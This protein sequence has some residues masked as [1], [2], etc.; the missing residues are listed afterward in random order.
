MA[1]TAWNHEYAELENLRVHYVRH[2]TGAPLIL[3]HG[4]PEF[5]Y[6]WRKNIPELAKSFDVIAPDLRGFGDSGK[7]DVTPTVET[8]AD[9]L[10]ALADHLGLERFGVVTHDVGSGIMQ[11]FA[12]RWT[13]RLSGL[14]LFNASYPGIGKRWAEADQ[15]AETWYQYFHQQDFAAELV[16]ASRESCRIYFRHFLSPWAHD[17]HAFD[18]D[19]EAWVD[20]FM[21]PG[22]LRGGFDWYRATNPSRLATIR[23]EAGPTDR[24]TT[25]TRVLW[26]AHDPILKAAWRDRLDEYFSDIRIGLAPDAGH[27]VHYET[28]ELANREIKAFFAPL[29][30]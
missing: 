14:F 11:V 18:D 6:A 21:K 4:W 3:I 25:P 9:D 7:S 5:W 13:K 22:N 20:N 27:F 28:P 29:I 16:G 17:D 19:I 8:Y 15:L 23:G 12:R 1:E 2:G 30:A 10:K 26:G 24:I